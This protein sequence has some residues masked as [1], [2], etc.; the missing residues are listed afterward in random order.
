MRNQ[1]LVIA[2]QNVGRGEKVFAVLIPTVSKD[3]NEQFKLAHKVVDVV[4]RA[5]RKI[6]VIL[7]RYSVD[8]P[9]TSYGQVQLIARKEEEER[10]Q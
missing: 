1:Q 3:M 7:L 10:F 8:Q 5:K 9:A 2:A 6:F 4:D